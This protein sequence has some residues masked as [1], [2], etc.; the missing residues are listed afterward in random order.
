[1]IP[2]PDD[3][4]LLAGRLEATARELAA[5]RYP[6]GADSEGASPAPA[7]AAGSGPAGIGPA[8]GTGRAGDVPGSTEP[9][10]LDAVRSASE[11]SALAG[12]A[13]RLAVDLARA[14]GRTWQ[15]LGE[16]LGVSRQAAFQRFG[17]P[18]DP[19]TGEPTGN[20]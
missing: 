1:V 15:E 13:L 16:V 11:L 8:A 7:G 20:I 2:T 10:G 14:A 4:V 9:A 19:P 18:V 6:A 3:L 5:S 17:H 12:D